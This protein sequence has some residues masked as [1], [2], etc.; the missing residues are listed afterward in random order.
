MRRRVDV[1]ARECIH[2]SFPAH[3]SQNV[4]VAN[5]QGVSHGAVFEYT[6]FIPDYASQTKLV[7]GGI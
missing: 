6:K 2:A 5:N 1:A 7:V 3:V 4:D